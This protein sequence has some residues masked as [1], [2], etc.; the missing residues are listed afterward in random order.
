MRLGFGTD[1]REGLLGRLIV[2]SEELKTGLY[3]LSNALKQFAVSNLSTE[4]PP[5]HFDWIQPWT[6]G[7]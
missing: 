7:R 4:V 5:E 6:V 1:D 2:A 3:Q